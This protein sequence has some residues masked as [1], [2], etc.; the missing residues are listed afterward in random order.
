MARRSGFG[1]PAQPGD[2]TW[3][4]RHH[5][6]SLW[7]SQG[8]DFIATPS[9]VAPAGIADTTVTWSSTGMID[10]VQ[11]WVNTP[12]SN[13]GWIFISSI[14]GTRQ[15]VKNFYSAE[16]SGFRPLIQIVARP[17]SAPVPISKPAFLF[18]QLLT[19]LLFAH[20]VLRRS[21]NGRA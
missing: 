16:S 18:V 17:P 20:L 15:R 1:A 14:E 10:D 3:V 11:Q 19:L 12:A 21:P 7:T 5:D 2:A 13:Y 8:G 9:A 6:S 4:S